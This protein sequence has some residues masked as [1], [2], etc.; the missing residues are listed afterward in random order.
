MPSTFHQRTIAVLKRVRRGKV[1]TYGQVAAMAGN[2]LAAR[3]VVRTLNTA[4]EKEKL[5]WHRVIN[6]QG[7]ISLKPGQGYELQKKLLQKEGVKFGRGG[8]I[9]LKK[10]QWV[11]RRRK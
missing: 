5:P 11:P 1:V 2:P 8:Q 3:Q 7:K 4:S 9:D 10:Y 6:S